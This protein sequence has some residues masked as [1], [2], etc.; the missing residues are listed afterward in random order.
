MGAELNGGLPGTEPMPGNVATWV[1]EKIGN[2]KARTCS[3]EDHLLVATELS[4]FTL[5]WKL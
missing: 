2:W 4:S 3:E 1:G 5:A